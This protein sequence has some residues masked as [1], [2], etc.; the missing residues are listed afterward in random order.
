MV[1]ELVTLLR[2]AYPVVNWFALGEAKK[3]AAEISRVVREYN[4]APDTPKSQAGLITV[5]RD[6]KTFLSSRTTEE[7]IQHSRAIAA[8]LAGLEQGAAAT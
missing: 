5:A 4:A 6:V 1:D 8:K 7:A 3:L 2:K